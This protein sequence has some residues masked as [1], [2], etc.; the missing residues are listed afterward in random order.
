MSRFGKLFGAGRGKTRKGTLTPPDAIQWLWDMMEMQS[1]KQEFLEMKLEQELTATKKPSTERSPWGLQAPKHRKRYRKQLAQID[2]T[3]S[4][5][6]FQREALDNARTNTELLKNMG[7]AAKATKAAHDNTAID[8]VDELKQDIADQ[9]ELARELSTAI[10]KPVGYGEGFDEDELMA[11]LEELE[12]EELDKNLL[13]VSG[14][15]TVPL[16]NVPSITLPSKPSKK[17][18]KED[19]MKELENWV[20]S[21]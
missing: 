20:G 21:I 7:S 14:P 3:L 5:M 17:E 1:K 9:Q 8:K 12:Q 2:G 4:T 16:P 6:E 13:E 10:S 11:E 19:D 18:E 15:A